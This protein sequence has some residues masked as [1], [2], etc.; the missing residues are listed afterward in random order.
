MY[1]QRHII[2]GDI[3]GC[4]DLLK[5]LLDRVR[6]DPSGDSLV[7]LGDFVDRGPDPVGV[8]R[9]VRK[10]CQESKARAVNGN[11]EEKMLHWLTNVELE[12]TKGRKN[13]M[14]R[15]K[16]ERLAQWEG[17]SPEDIK[18]LGSL[19]YQL[20]VCPGWLAVH[21]GFENRPMSEQLSERMCRVKYVNASTGSLVKPDRKNRNVPPTGAV[22][23]M[24]TW[25]GPESIVYGHIVHGLGAP[26][27]DHPAPGVETWGID[28]G[29]CY[30][31]NLSALVLETREVFTVSDG[32][33]YAR[34]YNDD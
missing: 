8:V 19:P 29:A 11:H 27:V 7:F 30:G 3:H 17:M 31:G 24:S 32:K 14:Q 15:P 1:A 34:L 9:L 26:R 4:L 2:I 20:K 10:L 18:W 28:T 6:F 21:A 25:R 16:P 23:W 5:R 22:E 12:K 33:S 13:S